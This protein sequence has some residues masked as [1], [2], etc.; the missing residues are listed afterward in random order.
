MIDSSIFIVSGLSW[1]HSIERLDL[2]GDEL[3]NQDVIEYT[4]QGYRPVLYEVDAGFCV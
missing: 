4:E 3:I 1:P 2:Q